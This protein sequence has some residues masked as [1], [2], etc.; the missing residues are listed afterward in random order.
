MD[1]KNEQ[2]Y[3]SVFWTAVVKMKRFLIPLVNEAFHEH[4]SDQAIVV[5]EPNKLMTEL[6]DGNFDHREMDAIATLSENGVE[7]G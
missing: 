5:L 3:D 7:K 6:P 4:Y 2:T 1:I